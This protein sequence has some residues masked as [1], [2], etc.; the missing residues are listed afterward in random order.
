MPNYN[1]FFS[2][3]YKQNFKIFEKIFKFL[4]NLIKYF[5]YIF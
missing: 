5:P 1:N 2:K 4:R 3:I